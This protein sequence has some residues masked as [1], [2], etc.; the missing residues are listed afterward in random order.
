MEI[1]GGLRYDTV[2]DWHWPTMG[3]TQLWRVPRSTVYGGD[4]TMSSSAYRRSPVLWLVVGLAMGMVLGHFLP[5]TPL[6]AVATDRYD[7]FA[8]ATGPVDG[9]VEAVY[10]LDFLTGELRAAVLGRQSGK[11]TAFYEYRNVPKDLGVEPA[12]NPRYLMVTGMADL[13]RGGARMRPS[14][15][16]VYIAEITTGTVAAYA[17]PWDKHAHASSRI[18]KG[19]LLPLDVTRFRT[20]AVRDQRAGGQ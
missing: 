17:I 12:K 2:R 10:F 13:V 9:E 6:H 18:V 4:S 7:T 15:A 8:I 20:A 5:H 16:V 14:L 3:P 19:T 1:L 11:F